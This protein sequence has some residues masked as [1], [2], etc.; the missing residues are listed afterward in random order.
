M[1]EK[2]LIEC[3]NNKDIKKIVDIIFAIA[4]GFAFLFGLRCVDA[5]DSHVAFAIYL[6]YVVILLLYIKAKD[7]KLVVTDKRIYGKAIWRQVDL[8]IDSVSS[9]AKGWF[10][11]LLVSTSS[12]RITWI[13]GGQREEVYKIISDLLIN[14]QG[15]SKNNNTDFKEELEKLKE[16]LDKKIITQEDFDKKKK[17]LLNL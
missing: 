9:V 5:G 1:K 10:G 14:R 6:I 2:K 7:M 16:L 12:G 8:P 17:E 11:S 3:T 4:G 15:N 13:I